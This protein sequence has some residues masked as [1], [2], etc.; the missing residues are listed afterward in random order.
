MFITSSLALDNP[1]KVAIKL[2]AFFEFFFPFQ[3][4]SQIEKKRH[5]SL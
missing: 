4:Y 2:V 5:L 3:L 1:I